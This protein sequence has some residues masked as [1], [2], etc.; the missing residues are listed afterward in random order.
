MQHL[1]LT[2]HKFKQTWINYKEKLNININKNNHW[3]FFFIFFE[4]ERTSWWHSCQTLI[5]TWSHDDLTQTDYISHVILSG[6]LILGALCPLFRLGHHPRGWRG[7][8]VWVVARSSGAHH[9]SLTAYINRMSAS[10][11]RK[12]HSLP[13]FQ[14][15]C[16]S[17]QS[18]R[19]SKSGLLQRMSETTTGLR[20]TCRGQQD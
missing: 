8:G 13:C 4:E 6:H 10:L 11:L 3:E 5:E 2:K 16:S 14:Y 17:I 12:P 1:N 19:S 15:S 18:K 9:D 7:W 20:R